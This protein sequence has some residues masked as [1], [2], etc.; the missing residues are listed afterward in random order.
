MTL[1]NYLSYF[2]Q[3]FAPTEPLFRLVPPDKIDWKPT[4][5]SFTCGQLMAHMAIALERYGNGIATGAWGVGSMKE[6]FLGNRR[7]PSLST[8][9]AVELLKTNY[10]LF[11]SLLRGLSEEDFNTGEVDSPQLGRV[12]RW[13]VAMLAV[14][15]HLDHK[16]ELF[17]YLK[18][19][20]V[21]VHTGHLYTRR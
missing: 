17:M 14:E 6:I 5:S 4:E 12:P 13:R 3:M 15:H 18:L 16:A 2:E 10:D 7:T 19:L 11:M 9:E 1:Q 21:R 20:G 8:D